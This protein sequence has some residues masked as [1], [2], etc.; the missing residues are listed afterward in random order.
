MQ[1]SILPRAPNEGVSAIKKLVTKCVLIQ[2]PGLRILDL[3]HLGCSKRR[4]LRDLLEWIEN[5]AKTRFQPVLYSFALNS[6]F[7]N[8]TFKAI[9]VAVLRLYCQAYRALGFDSLSESRSRANV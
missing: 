4:L 1:R 9:T 2:F 7:V 8:S 5:W 3:V 6:K